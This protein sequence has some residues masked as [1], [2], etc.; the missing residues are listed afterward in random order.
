[1]TSYSGMEPLRYHDFHLRGYSVLDFGAR[2]VLDLVLHD[3]DSDWYESSIT[4]SGVVC[5]RFTHPSGA[6]I[7][8]IDEVD[9]AL[10]VEEEASFLTDAAKY[11]LEHWTLGGMEE[12]VAN[13]QREG[14][15][16]WRIESAIGFGGFVIAKDVAGQCSIV[17]R[18]SL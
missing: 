17:R 3:R 14:G 4:F 13:L 9:L 5:Y 12:Y 6:I 8:E 2:I 11:G 10:L 18:P 7:T 16:A 1:M 15:R